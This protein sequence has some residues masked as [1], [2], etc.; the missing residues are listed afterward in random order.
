MKSTTTGFAASIAA[1]ALSAGCGRLG[2]DAAVA[3]ASLQTIDGYCTECHN[4]A[5]FAGGVALDAV[6][7]ENVAANAEVL[8]KAVR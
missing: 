6:S 5:E 7:P 8:E 1:L 2:G 4:G 3:E